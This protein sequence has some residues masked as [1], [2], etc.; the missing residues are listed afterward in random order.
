MSMKIR[1]DELLGMPA[2]SMTPLNLL[3]KNYL[4]W[5]YDKGRHGQ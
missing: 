5:I 2:L 4:R 1:D 3:K